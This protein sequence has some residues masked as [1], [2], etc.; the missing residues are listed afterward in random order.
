MA[1]RYSNRKV[2]RNNNKLYKEVF[3]ERGVNFIRQFKSP[4]LK[5]PTANE[6][7]SLDK[8][9]HI[10]GVGDRYYKLAHKYYGEST[11]WWVIAW[12]NKKPTEAHVKTGEVIY[13]PLPLYTIL[14]LLNV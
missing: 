8:I 6:M 5:Y 7:A 13:V 9:G 10:W 4:D 11:Y 3:K 2:A 12:F 14:N 1:T